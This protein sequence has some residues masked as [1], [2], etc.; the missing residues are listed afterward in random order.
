MPPVWA[1]VEANQGVASIQELYRSEN[2][3]CPF[4]NCLDVDFVLIICDC[5]MVPSYVPY[6]IIHIDIA[7]GSLDVHGVLRVA[8]AGNVVFFGRNVGGCEVGHRCAL[9]DHLVRGGHGCV[10]LD[11]GQLAVLLFHKGP[12][13]G[14]LPAKLNY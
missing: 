8:T 13:K 14:F 12:Y 10:F 7:M 1:G 2:D 3:L 9:L 5:N 6:T 11:L 4:E